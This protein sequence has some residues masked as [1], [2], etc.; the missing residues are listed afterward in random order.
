MIRTATRTPLP[1]TTLLLAALVLPLRASQSIVPAHPAAVPRTATA[2][3]Y[4]PQPLRFELNTGQVDSRVRFT[5]RTGDTALFLTAQQSVFRLHGD[6]DAASAVLR[7]T[8][9]AANVGATVHGVELLSGV[10]HYFIGNDP[11]AWKT[12][13][14][15]YARVRYDE[16]Y[17][18]ID[19]VYYGTD[20]GEIEYDFELAP[21][22][23]PRRIVLAVEG[24]T[25]VAIDGEGGDLVLETAV[26]HVRQHAPV[27]YQVVDGQRRLIDARYLLAAD[28][29][30]TH[31]TFDVAA[32]DVTRPL[33]IDP[34]VV[35][36]TL[37]GGAGGNFDGIRDMAT[38]A[39]GNAYVTGDTESGDFPVGGGFD[40]A[41]PLRND[42]KAFVTKFGPNGA[43]V[44]S[45]FLGSR[46][47]SSAGAAIAVDDEG[48]IYVAGT[49]GDGFPVRNGFQSRPE[50]PSDA[51]IA[52]LSAD[53]SSLIYATYLGGN[54]SESVRD[55]ALD[56]NR[57][58]Y[59]TGE[60]DR[61]GTGAVTFP[62]VGA[63]QQGYGGGGT[64]VFLSVISTDGT[65]LLASTLFDVGKNGPQNQAGDE[66]VSSIAVDPKSRNI[67]IGGG[68]TFSP[69]NDDEKE[70]PFLV[71]VRLGYDPS[72]ARASG[73]RAGT[74]L[75]PNFYFYG[76]TASELIDEAYGSNTRFAIKI[77][78]AFLFGVSGEYSPSQGDNGAA[79]P[80]ADPPAPPEA[81]VLASGR[82]AIVPPARTCDEPLSFAIFDENLKVKRAA[83]VTGGREF[84]PEATTQDA[85]GNIYVA[86]STTS[87]R[88]PT[89][90]PVQ[91]APAPGGRDDIVVGAYRRQT[92]QP[93]FVTYFGGD[94]LETP[95]SIVVDPDG[96]IYVAGIVT[97]ATN[98]PASPGAFQRDPK[99]RNDGFLVKFST[100]IPPLPKP[101]RVSR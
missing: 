2:S 56:V 98:F 88:V 93:A 9:I 94:G 27:V 80:L 69:D 50:S 10:S 36:A 24:A 39:R 41:P 47:S 58:V 70:E 19:L 46:D 62:E 20:A 12:H 66:R 71:Q 54:Q 34:V 96:N 101:S 51:F 55:L 90:S 28:G 68:V 33:V 53:G 23:D 82:C 74:Q 45:T 57:R 67:V 1:L 22:A 72:R 73:D 79:T 18:G 91:S 60:V 42:F 11:A 26:G 17:P 3:P 81:A 29:A 40:P 87:P 30:A 85:D 52:K 14:P 49:S 25:A 38:D 61:D 78:L 13:V 77:A 84:F 4:R 89:V 6:P 5:A 92:L 63:V 44:F 37:L 99:G 35:Y 16:V 64:D 21:G 32:Y 48:A 65:E 59:V 83:N 86:G 15:S 95:T 31:L 75:D 8:P 43:M 7:L 100:A 97:L 76:P